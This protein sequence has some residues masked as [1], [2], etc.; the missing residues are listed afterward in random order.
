MINSKD[1]KEAWEAGY[2]A[3]KRDVAATECPWAFKNSPFWEK[4]DYDGFNR[5]WHLLLDQWMSG[6]ITANKEELLK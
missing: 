5:E 4:K 3:R 1:H 6:W 2:E